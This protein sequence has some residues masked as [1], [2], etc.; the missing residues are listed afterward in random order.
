METIRDITESVRNGKRTA[1]ERIREA[2]SRIESLNPQAGAFLE[3]VDTEAANAAA[4]VGAARDAEQPLSGVAVAIKDNICATRGKTTCGSRML[5]NF[6]SPFDATAVRRLQSAGAIVVGKTNLD[7]FAMGGSTE[8]SAFHQ[9]VNPWDASRVPGGSSGG[10]AAAV[11]LGMV[12]VALGSDTGGSIRQPAGFCG[13]I[14]LKPT[15]GRVSRYGLVAYGSSLDQIGPIT[16]TVEDAARVL[17]VIAG[18]DPCDATSSREAVP[19]YISQ[20]TDE[21]IDA[22]GKS[23]RIGVARGQFASGVQ[24]AVIAA[25]E[26]AIAE[27]EKL[28]A[29][30]VDIDL[31]HAGHGVA[32]YYLIATAE[33]ASNLARF[34][35]VHY[36]K[37]TAQSGDIV[38]LYSRSRD[39]TLGAEV[40]RRIMLGTFA[41]SE[42]YD[43]GYYDKASRIRR[44]LQ[45]DYLSAFES[46]DLILGPVSPTTAFKIGEKSDDPLQMYLADQFTVAANLTGLPAISVPGGYDEAGLP[47]G[48]QLTAPAFRELALLQGARLFERATDWISKKSPPGI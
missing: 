39:E 35:G 13:V 14:G 48:V 8:N 32:A 23:L 20:L 21:K 36:G 16:R 15:Y 24:P 37:R 26:A 19:D 47:I 7:E 6:R 43:A 33:A 18:H 10:S 11:A 25:I 3:F 29:T 46:V 2:L 4:A 45:N 28:G 27:F 9:T 38:D 40:K 12:P 42:G 22:H 30:I 31:P 17:A 44:L 1:S 41:L 5:A 34:D